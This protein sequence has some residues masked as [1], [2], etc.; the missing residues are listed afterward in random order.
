MIIIRDANTKLKERHKGTKFTE[1]FS[2]RIFGFNKTSNDSKH[3]YFVSSDDILKIFKKHNMDVEI[4]D[5]TKL[6]SNVVYIIKKN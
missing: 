2:T 4:V 6:T 1:L 5:Q 3:L